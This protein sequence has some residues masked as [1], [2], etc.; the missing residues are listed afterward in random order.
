MYDWKARLRELNE[1]KQSVLCLV[2]NVV[3]CAETGMDREVW[4]IV[5]HGIDDYNQSV[6][7]RGKT[8]EG[9]IEMAFDSSR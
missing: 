8:I 2:P 1:I 4:D 5:E 7:S 6:V 3:C 9:A